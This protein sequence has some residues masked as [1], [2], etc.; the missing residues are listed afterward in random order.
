M[1]AQPKLRNS[2]DAMKGLSA[3]QPI[4]IPGFERWL[5]EVPEQFP[6][7]AWRVNGLDL[8][9]LFST[10][11]VSLSIL[12]NLGQRRGGVRTGSQ[13]WRAGVISQYFMARRLA[14]LSRNRAKPKLPQDRLEGT[15]VF[16]G[17]SLHVRDFGGLAVIAPLDVPS[18]LMRKQGHRCTL[19]IDDAD[20]D[21]PM[22][23]RTLTQPAYG[24]SAFLHRAAAR[25]SRHDALPALQRLPGFKTW[26]E[27][28]AK[29][30]GLPYYFFR[31]WLARQINLALST[32]NCYD[33][34]FEER[35]VPALLVILNAGFASTVALTFA[36]RRRGIDVIEVQHGAESEASVTAKGSVPHFSTY[37]T[38]PS[39]LISWELAER[40]D[41]NVLAMG[42]IGLHLP[43]IMSLPHASDQA[44]QH[45]FRA[46]LTRQAEELKAYA[47]QVGARKEVL[48]SLQPGDD[49]SWLRSFASENRHGVLFWVRRHG[50]DLLDPAHPKEIPVTG[51]IEA[52]LA[53]T[54]ALPILLARSQVHLTRFS[55]VT[56][57]AAAMGLPT[58]ATD[59]YAR[60][61]Y[62]RI[63]PPDL[64]HVDAD[65]ARAAARLQELIEEPS[66]GACSTL[67]PA[68]R[69]APF[70]A[71]FCRAP[72]SATGKGEVPKH[73][74]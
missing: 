53:S 30:L 11:L 58:I 19:W 23:A 65:L 69:F 26:S 33:T 29:E 1:I 71:N 14:R 2:L 7:T 37:N 8:W 47:E 59:T 72:L 42:P 57:E 38:A 55:A 34:I 21:A 45:A 41:P 18:A 60:Q 6:V 48:V 13:V 70:I 16:H 43:A 3:K 74:A 9:P 46:A 64:L 31:I 25:S 10:S 39:A 28:A 44:A 36:A 67:P 50:A 54:C 52:E 4:D 15:I 63:V 24:L 66:R 12:L 56:I 27:L 61:L 17:S 32:A 20:A 40:H 73:R 68:S 35:G 49:G 51:M 22:L 5:R 62:E